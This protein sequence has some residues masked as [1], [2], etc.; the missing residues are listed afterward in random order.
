MHIL[1]L[2]LNSEDPAI[3]YKTRVHLLGEDSQNDELC[4]LRQSI[5]TSSRARELLSHRASDGTL[6]FHPYKKWIGA[7]WTLVS[8]AD[9]E[10]P[11]GDPALFPLRDQVFDWLLVRDKP[12]TLEGRVRTCASQEGNA[13]YATLALGIADERVHELAVRLMIWQWPDGGWNCDKNPH[14]SHSSFMESLIPLRALALYI[15][16]TADPHA[17]IVVERAADLF[18]KRHLFKRQRDGQV[19]T[20]DFITLHYP[21]YWH[22]DILFALKVMAEAGFIHDPR[23]QDALDLLERKR[24]PNGGFPV[25][26]SYYRV[27]DKVPS[28][29]SLVPWG[30]Q[31]R[32]KMN[33]FVTT[34]AL[35]V[36]KA[37]GKILQDRY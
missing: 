12:L 34:D 9:L 3:R 32:K 15:R 22:Y 35:F 11:P 30:V 7:H 16:Q 26:K 18:L 28:G 31:H 37:A 29:R 1:E 19:I 21:C 13:L 17:K 5:Q 20:E 24:L 23:C 10:Y 6:P 36:L 8:L 27:S 14:A 25:E 33:E 4:R 2:L